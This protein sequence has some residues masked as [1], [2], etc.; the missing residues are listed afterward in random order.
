MS[1]TKNNLAALAA[2]VESA[3]ARRRS[4]SA[5]AISWIREAALLPV[6]AVLLV[7]GGIPGYALRGRDERLA[8]EGWRGEFGEVL[9]ADQ[10]DDAITDGQVVKLISGEQERRSGLRG[11]PGEFG[12][13]QGL[14]R[15]VH[16]AGRGDGDNEPRFAGQGAGSGNLLLVPAR[17]LTHGLV[18]PRRHDGQSLGQR[19]R[20]RRPG[21]GTQEAR[22]PG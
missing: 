20:G 1:D 12:Q 16:A 8:V 6:L 4:R 7:V 13:E 14:G 18:R 19:R 9:T 10:D 2:D 11:H 15:H 21:P 22:Q 3:L 5:A 17:K